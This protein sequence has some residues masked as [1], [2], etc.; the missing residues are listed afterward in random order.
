MWCSHAIQKDDFIDTCFEVPNSVC[1]AST[2]Q[3]ITPKAVPENLAAHWYDAIP[4]LGSVTCGRFM[5]QEFQLAVCW[6][7]TILLQ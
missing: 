4:L 2:S 7:F 1:L 3:V 5:W 6:Y